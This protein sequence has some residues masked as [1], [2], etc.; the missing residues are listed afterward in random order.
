MKNY[1]ASILVLLI[2]AFFAAG[3]AARIASIAQERA[4]IRQFGASPVRAPGVPIAATRLDS[5]ADIDLGPLEVM[6]TVLRSVRE[7]FVD[8]IKPSDEGRMAREALRAMLAS[9]DDPNTRFLDPDQMKLVGEALN[10]QYHGIGAFLAIKKIKVGNIQEEHLVVITP[11]DNGPAAKAGLRPGDDIVAIDGRDVLPLDPFQR[12][13]EVIKEERKKAVDKDVIRKHIES[14]TK[15]IEEGIPILKAERTLISEDDKEFELTVVR[16][17]TPKPIKV[18][19]KTQAFSV[20]PVSWKLI[21]NDRFACIR[22]S[23]FTDRTADELEG[24]VRDLKSK[25]VK[26]VILDLRNTAA[27]SLETV[28]SAAKV[29]IP[30]RVFAVEHKSRNRKLPI[31]VEQCSED[32]VWSGPLVVLVNSGTA[33][34][35]EVLAAALKD[36]LSTKLVGESSYGDPSAVTL[37]ELRDGS[38]ITMT[39][40]RLVPLRSPDIYG[41]GLSPDV[42]VASDGTQD[43]QLN[44]AVEL[45]QSLAAKT[46]QARAGK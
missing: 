34:M 32:R 41:K 35:A 40:G 14:E 19:I 22:I 31:R 6:L 28:L 5:A 4:A 25:G 33:R 38:G 15:R 21:N 17:G 16:K 37:V 24:A 18:R 29:F 2:A 42:P 30:G 23:C 3:W 1:K 11:I 46:M 9:L 10:G 45:L 7:H 13:S 27:G 12:A 43:K 39:T 20:D 8:P 44:E 26:G 36:N